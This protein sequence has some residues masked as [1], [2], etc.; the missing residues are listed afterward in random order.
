MQAIKPPPGSVTSAPGMQSY[1]VV[2]PRRVP[3]STDRSELYSEGLQAT[4]AFQKKLEGWIVAENLQA[5]V[6]GISPATSLP[7]LFL[8]C[9]SYFASRVAER[10]DVESVLPD[11]PM[12]QLL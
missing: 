5:E 4:R 8:T 10:E 7:M 3:T 1:M 9:T 12:L 6:G 2:I 11:D